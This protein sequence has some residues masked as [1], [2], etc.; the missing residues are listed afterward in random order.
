MWSM[1]RGLGLLCVLVFAL[2]GSARAGTGGYLGDFSTLKYVAAPGESNTVVWTW[3]DYL[4]AGT[5]V[6]LA[7]LTAP[8]RASAGCTSPAPHVLTCDDWKSWIRLGDRN[9]R[10]SAPHTNRWGSVFT[11][12]HEPG[13][14]VDGGSG[15]D[16][17]AAGRDDVTDIYGGPGNDRIVA[18][19]EAYSVACGTGNDTVT[20]PA[21]ALVQPDCEHVTRIG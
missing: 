21:A 16:V 12:W 19:A 6:Q 1:R 2:A 11:S 9:D 3:T 4:V 8:V 5:T 13:M 10:F 15:D 14:I 7:D 17:I 18:G 20:A